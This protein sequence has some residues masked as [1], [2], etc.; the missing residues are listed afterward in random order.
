MYCTLYDRLWHAPP[1]QNREVCS[2]VSRP[3]TRNTNDGMFF[4]PKDVPR[5]MSRYGS[6][7]RKHRTMYYLCYLQER[8][9]ICL[10]PKYGPASTALFLVLVSLRQLGPPISIPPISILRPSLQCLSSD[11]LV[12]IKASSWLLG[13]VV[14]SSTA[15]QRSFHERIID[16]GI[17]GCLDLALQKLPPP[18]IWN[19]LSRTLVTWM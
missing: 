8:R 2:K 4:M 12:A 1:L 19:L 14:G 7:S 6:A 3:L 13:S 9:K 16:R 10:K 5:V 11:L 15:L 17:L 18:Y